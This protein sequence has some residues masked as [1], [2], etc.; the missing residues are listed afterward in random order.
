[1]PEEKDDV[2]EFDEFDFR[3]V[4]FGELDKA[5]VVEQFALLDTLTNKQ[6]NQ[7]TDSVEGIVDSMDRR[8]KLLNWISFVG[9]LGLTIAGIPT[10]PTD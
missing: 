1:M 3:E 8:A 7:L 10:P 6:I 9:K 4:D 5:L 2:L